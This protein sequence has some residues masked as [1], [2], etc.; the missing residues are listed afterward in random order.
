MPRILSGVLFTDF[1]SLISIRSERGQYQGYQ[2]VRQVMKDQG[3]GN[4]IRGLMRARHCTVGNNVIMCRIRPVWI[5]HD[6]SYQLGQEVCLYWIWTKA[7]NTKTESLDLFWAECLGGLLYKGVY[8]GKYQI[9]V[10][11]YFETLDIIF[12]DCWPQNWIPG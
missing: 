3:W 8:K 7:K 5:I 4:V 12:N 9:Y 11:L 10:K 1:T 6:K 2:G